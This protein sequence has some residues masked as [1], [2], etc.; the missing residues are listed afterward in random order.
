[1]RLSIAWKSN[2]H[3]SI[4]IANGGS[5]EGTCRVI[6]STDF[7]LLVQFLPPGTVVIVRLSFVGRSRSEVKALELGR[8]H[9]LFQFFNQANPMKFSAFDKNNRLLFLVR[10]ER[11]PWEL[12]IIAVVLDFQVFF[13]QTNRLNSKDLERTRCWCGRKWKKKMRKRKCP[14]C[15]PISIEKFCLL[16]YNNNSAGVSNSYME[17][18]KWWGSINKLN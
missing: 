6:S 15:W 16:C 14:L 13:A 18:L 4:K 2:E 10:N 7:D 3:G 1:M 8:G 11:S 9:E 12:Y 5:K 17:I